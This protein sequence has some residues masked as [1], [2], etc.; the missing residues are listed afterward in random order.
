MRRGRGANEIPG[1]IRRLGS[2]RS[3]VVDAARARL[4]IVGS[5]A[6]EALIETLDGDDH[7][8]R[9]HAMALLALI[10]DPRGREPLQAMLLDRDPRLRAIA[11]RC[12]SRY[13][14]PG[15]VIGLERLLDVESSETVR[16]AAAE[17][18]VEQVAGGEERALCRLLELLYDRDEREPVRLAALAL[19]PQLRPAQ[20]RG[21]LRS[22]REDDD[23]VAR[24]ARTLDG[25]G[26]AIPPTA[27]TIRRH[28]LALAE[29][30]Y[31]VWNESVHALAR[32]GT[33]AVEPTIREMERRPHDPEYC[34]RAGMALKALGPRRARGIADAIERVD[35][36]LPLQVLVDVIGA[37]GERSMIYRLKDLIER[38][39]DGGA[40]PGVDD[41]QRV[42]AMAHLELARIG[43]RVAVAD[44]HAVLADS[45]RRCELEILDALEL[46]GKRDEIDALL[47]LWGREDRLGR[48]RIAATVRAIMKRERIR[49]NNPMFR[50][51]G[52]G[53]REAFRAILGAGAPRRPPGRRRDARSGPRL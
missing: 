15:S 9:A 7:R 52:A 36:P 16:V 49:R 3:S 44:L 10:G 29:A 1:L 32:C 18:L 31:A 46:I 50:E 34:A 45:G 17:S 30:D 38:I 40:P 39:G 42:R 28:V 43:S 51:L 33:A 12:L 8:R 27:P 4:A 14:H 22:L 19:L 48:E 35:E 21:V 23:A 53:R 47:D 5:R 41:L 37:L 26:A 13:V 6:V 2:R 24:R 25:P 20:R 11:A